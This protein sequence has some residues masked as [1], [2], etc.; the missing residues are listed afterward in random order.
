MIWNG[1]SIVLYCEHVH[2]LLQ[3]L[4]RYS[5]HSLISSRKFP[6]VDGQMSI[7]DD[8]HDTLW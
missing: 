2:F 8:S 4:I 3:T 6:L 5:Y 1:F 7:F